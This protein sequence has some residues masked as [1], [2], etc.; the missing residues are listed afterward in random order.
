M[1]SI[2]GEN[3]SQE[4]GGMF[5]SSGVDKILGSVKVR[6]GFLSLF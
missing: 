4:G 2:T 3:Y 1:D 6:R 5:A